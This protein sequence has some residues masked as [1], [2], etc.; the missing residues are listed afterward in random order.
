MQRDRDGW[1]PRRGRSRCLK[2]DMAMQLDKSSRSSRRRSPPK[3]RNTSSASEL[4][5]K[6]EIEALRR[7]KKQIDDYAQKALTGW[8]A[9]PAG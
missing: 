5:T 4:L 6:S 2:G 7:S 9:K 3:K 8:A 1:R